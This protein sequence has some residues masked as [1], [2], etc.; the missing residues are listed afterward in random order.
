[1]F[2][3]MKITSLQSNFLWK[4]ARRNMS[5]QKKENIFMNYKDFTDFSLY[6]RKE[7]MKHFI[8]SDTNHM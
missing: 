5:T 8:N 7:K 4:S 3:K 1:M 2:L 6:E